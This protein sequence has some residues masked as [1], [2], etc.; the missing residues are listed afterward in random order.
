MSLKLGGS[1]WRTYS[2]KMLR[3]AG[4][5]TVEVRDEAGQVLAR[6]EFVCTD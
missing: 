5:W 4:D 3:S 1:R 6:T 2:A